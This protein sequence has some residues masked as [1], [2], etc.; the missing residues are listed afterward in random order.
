MSKSAFEQLTPKQQRFVEEYCIDMNGT[1][2]YKRAGYSASND[3]VANTSASRLL[4]NVNVKQAIEEKQRKIA[5][6]SGITAQWVLDRLQENVERCM[7]R[8]PVMIKVDGE[9]VESGEWKFDSAGANK[10]L[11]LLGKYLKMFTDKVESEQ[12]GNIR[13]N[14]NIP[15]PSEE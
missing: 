5:E 3:K 8:V 11:E 9:W 7:Q 2:A 13:V 10:S 6:Q 15:R 14:F 12:T 1:Q 4:S